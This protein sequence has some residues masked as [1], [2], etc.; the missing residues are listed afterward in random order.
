METTGPG[1]VERRAG[2]DWSRLIRVTAAEAALAEIAPVFDRPESL[3]LVLRLSGESG[4]EQARYGASGAT[5]EDGGRWREARIPGD[6]DWILSARHAGGEPP[7]RGEV[8]RAAAVIAAWRSARSEIARG[9]QKLRGRA[10]ELDMLQD[11]G[12]CAAAARTWDALFLDAA[13]VLEEG[14][15]ADLL[16]AAHALGGEAEV[17]VFLARPA[18]DAVI[19]SL[20][21]GAAAAAELPP[22]LPVRVSIEKLPGYDESHSRRRPA[23]AGPDS[24]FAPLTRRGRTV[25]ALGIVPSGR[26][27]ERMLRLFFGA[28]NQVSL[29][30]DRILTVLEAEQD[31]F[32]SILDSMPQAVILADRSLRVVVANRSA[33]AL[34]GR[35]DPRAGDEPL[36]RV[37]D[38]ELAPLAAGILDRGEAA[39][40]EEAR[41]PGGTIL[42]VTV[43]GLAGKSGRPE[44]LV[45]VLADVTERRRLQAQLAQAEKM[46]SLGELISGI[47]HELNN[48]LSSVLGYSQL[49]RAGA[50]DPK[51]AARL[52]VV[53]REARR[54]QKIVQN[55]LSFARRHE[56]ERKLMSVNEVVQSVIGLMSYQFRV[57]D[58]RIEAELG[59]DVPTIF[60]DAHQLQQTVLNL[61]SN[62]QQAIRGAGRG[63]VVSVTT[64]NCGPGWISLEVADDGPGIPESVRSR[65][66]EP[67]FTTKAPGQ[68][69]GLGLSLVESAVLAHGGRISVESEDGRGTTFRIELPVGSATAAAGECAA[70][71]APDVAVAP[72]R[73][74]VVD[75]EE[76]VVRMICETL[77]G[78]GHVAEPVRDGNEALDRLRREEFDLVVADLRMPGMGGASLCEEMERMRP[79]IASRILLTTGDT[80]SREPEALARSRGIAIL[81][82]PFDLDELRRA[83]RSRLRAARGIAPTGR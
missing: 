61:M 46:S 28:T 62:A 29:H 37:G 75:D 24:S 21:E 26:A 38:L 22:E 12:R 18:A 53:H 54:C 13:A 2:L 65:V 69:T 55:L 67:F 56:P 5:G 47:A 76:A 32:R 25:A 31:R 4:R 30:L 48:P 63:G 27:S 58:V 52:D 83:V 16:V 35:L 81:M 40:E 17:R 68:G 39:S 72:G 51:L 60:G 77:A 50:P 36:A 9:E 44:A 41:L 7:E 3:D 14:T 34:L 80:M 33:A 15:G 71:E 79:G 23:S 43:S 8:E 82:K 73:I 74:L 19:E 20:A 1:K 10:R 59:R 57:S 64:R 11:L 66:F 6:P 49:A 78:D 42:A 45:L 70:A